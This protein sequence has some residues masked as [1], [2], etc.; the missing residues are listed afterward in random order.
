M[1]RFGH[2]PYYWL[3]WLNIVIPLCQTLWPFQNKVEVCMGLVL[4]SSCSVPT[5]ILYINSDAVV[6][7]K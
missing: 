4:K 3:S 6:N 7:L 1:Q 5:C 2:K